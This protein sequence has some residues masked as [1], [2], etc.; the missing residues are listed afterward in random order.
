MQ[1]A[2]S[3]RLLGDADADVEKDATDAKAAES[4]TD[5][6]VNDIVPEVM[7]LC[8]HHNYEP[9]TPLLSMPQLGSL[10]LYKG[11]PRPS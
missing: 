2:S 1:A 4:T 11:Y 9:P 8:E 7:I 6:N 10:F 5:T 3:R